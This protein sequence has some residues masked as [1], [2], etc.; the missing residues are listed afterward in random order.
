MMGGSGGGPGA[1]NYGQLAQA[2]NPQIADPAQNMNNGGYPNM[3]RPQDIRAQI[4]GGGGKYGDFNYRP[5]TGPTPPPPPG[6]GGMNPNIRGSLPGG[7]EGGGPT[8]IRDILGDQYRGPDSGGIDGKL[9]EKGGNYGT[10]FGQR[11]LD[12]VINNTVPMSPPPGGQRGQQMQALQ[13][14]LARL[15]P[16][17]GITSNQPR[18][19]K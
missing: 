12:G 16:G 18:G 11:G 4:P 8:D 2:A 14:L 5:Q 1:G 9:H 3:R 10:G 17:G 6:L 13:A 7:P 19:G 15:Q